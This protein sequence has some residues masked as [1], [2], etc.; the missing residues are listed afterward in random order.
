M[1]ALITYAH[2]NPES[3][4]QAIVQRA[5]A[6]LTSRGWNVTVQNLYDI[7]FNPILTKED[8]S[9]FRAGNIPEDIAKQQSLVKEANLLVFVYPLWWFDRPAILKGWFDRV[10]SYGF[11]YKVGEKGPEGLLGNKRAVIIQTAGGLQ[12]QYELNQHDKIVHGTMREGTLDFCGIKDI[13]C[14]TFYSVTSCP[15]EQRLSMLDKV[16]ELVS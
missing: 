10:M 2:P 7:E 16:A 4:N 6:T 5:S 12:E 9:S 14:H 15:Q 13:R 8:L 1:K 3:F 11:A